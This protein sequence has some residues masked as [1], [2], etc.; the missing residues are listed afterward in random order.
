MNA[1]GG[2]TGPK[3]ASKTAR[4]PSK[5]G[6][7]LPLG[8]HAGNTGGKPGRS[9]R[10]P[11]DVTTA[12]R[13]IV[14]RHK[15]LEEAARIATRGEKDTDR[16]AAIRLIFSYAFGQPKEQVDLTTGGRPFLIVPDIE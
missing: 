13:H 5:G 7:V 12:A 3:T 4:P 16:L 10:R 14:D 2:Q 1:I 15:L 11:L 9:G 6:A 8:A